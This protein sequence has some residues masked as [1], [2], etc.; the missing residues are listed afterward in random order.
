LVVLGV[1][2]VRLL[3]ERGRFHAADT[4]NTATALALY[5]I[6]LV[7][8]TG[9]KVLAPAFYA[10]GTPRVPLV[11]SASAVLT[12]LIVIGV[13]HGR[14]G[15]RS[16]A[17][18]TA[19]GSLVNALIL[20]GMFQG[21]VGGLFS[22]G[23]LSRLARMVVAAAIMGPVAWFAARALETEVGTHGLVAQ[24]VTGLGPIVAGGLVYAIAAWALRLPEARTLWGAVVRRRSRPVPPAE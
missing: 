23:L 18:G 22:G 8:Y 4:E 21:R 15:Y 24:L 16:I 3:F 19:L 11:A 6:G 14:L 20:A 9:V 2:I 12:N 10:L 5:S 1:P 17:L 13:L 7:A